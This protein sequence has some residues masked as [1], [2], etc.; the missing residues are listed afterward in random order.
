M[1]KNNFSFLI[2]SLQTVNS[3][4]NQNYVFNGEFEQSGNWQGL[5]IV[6]VS[7]VRRISSNN[8]I[9]TIIFDTLHDK[10]TIINSRAGN[11]R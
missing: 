2:F 6:T 5:V 4:Y 7:N 10:C 11:G 3:F 1:L 9:R 8:C